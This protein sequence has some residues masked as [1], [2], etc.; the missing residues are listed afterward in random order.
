M[1][2]IT[3]RAIPAWKRR[4][5]ASILSLPCWAADDPDLLVV[6]ST[7][8]GTYQL[9]A[10]TGGTGSRRQVTFDP[11]GVLDGR[12]TADGTGVIWFRDGPAPRRAPGL[13]RRSAGRRAGAAA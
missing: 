12:P 13:S 1:V 4:F 10:G 3:E 5:R 6:G 8:S 2:T 9:H 7:E 11:V